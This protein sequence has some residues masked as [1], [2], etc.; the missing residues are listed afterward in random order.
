MSIGVEEVKQL[1]REVYKRQGFIVIGQPPDAVRKMQLGQVTERIFQFEVEAEFLLS[2]SATQQNWDQ[3]NDL[4]AELRPHWHRFPNG[5]GGC[6]FKLVPVPVKAARK[7][8]LRA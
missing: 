6:F 1:L 7:E 2:E 8:R 5:I 3:Q 4:I